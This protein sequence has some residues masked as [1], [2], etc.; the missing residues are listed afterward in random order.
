MRRV[1]SVISRQVADRPGPGRTM[2]RDLA[3]CDVRVRSPSQ[4]AVQV[5]DVTSRPVE[6][7]PGPVSPGPTPYALATL[8]GAV[9][10]GA[11]LH[12][13]ATEDG[14][15]PATAQKDLSFFVSQL[16]AHSKR[17][18][19]ELARAEALLNG[20]AAGYACPSLTHTHAHSMPATHTHT[21][22]YKGRS[23]LDL[24]T[25]WFPCQHWWFP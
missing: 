22:L 10:D 12:G 5:V 17:L 14:G 20:L 1:E 19:A 2:G 4:D 9:S 16:R 13:A 15:L 21:H 3:E 24:S 18:R 7:Q 23:L 8:D 11:V 25:R 6:P